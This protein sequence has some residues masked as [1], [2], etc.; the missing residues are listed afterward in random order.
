MKITLFCHYYLSKFE[1]T[2][3]DSGGQGSLS[4]TVHGLQKVRHEL[5]NEQDWKKLKIFYNSI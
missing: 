2:P 1:Q 4:A 3:V 5:A